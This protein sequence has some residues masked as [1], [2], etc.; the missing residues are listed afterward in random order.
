MGTVDPAPSVSRSP[1]PRWDLI[2]PVAA[3]VVAVVLVVLGIVTRSARSERR[4][5]TLEGRLNRVARE[6]EVALREAAPDRAEE[7]LDR[8][9]GSSGDLLR[10]LVLMRPD[11]RV[12]AD[13]GEPTG[14]GSL[15]VDL[16]LGP[17][18]HGPEPLFGSPGRGRGAGGGAGIGRNRRVLRLVPTTDAL[19]PPWAER[20]LLPVLVL[21][22]SGLVG[23]SVVGGRLLVRR[24]REVVLEA[25]RQR[26]EGLARA[27]AGLAHQLRTP[28]ATIQG[29][30]QLLLERRAETDDAPSLRRIL[31]QAR[32]M[33][34]LLGDLLDYARP[35]GAE[36]RA[37]AVGGV[38]A[39]L[40]E[41]DPR[42]RS[43]VEPSLNVRADP[44]HLRQILVNLVDNALAAEPGDDSGTDPGPVELSARRVGP[45][46]ETVEITVA[47][48]GPGPGDDPER[49]FEPY[50]TGRA[51]G[52]GLGLPIARALARANG[53]EV[54]LAPRPGGGTV[55]TLRLPGAPAET[56]SPAR[57]GRRPRRAP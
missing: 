8:T 43:E 30:S 35:T 13:A 55:A 53:G 26:L 9:L 36:P 32:R 45:S 6:V 5:L 10:G 50:V 19:R 48:R 41:V 46:G 33:D 54:A 14:P 49:L 22:A 52:T 2:L 44:E 18:G 56:A 28:L 38:A 47:D 57:T 51:D 11:G 21:A 31:E 40:A 42:L 34:R 37:V 23:L 15:E 1:A 29:T 20:L 3:L 7:V 27:G 12:Q 25:E 39:E 16:F 17:G 24:Q 4:A